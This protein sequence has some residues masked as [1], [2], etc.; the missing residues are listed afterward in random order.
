MLSIKLQNSIGPCVCFSPAIGC[1][2]LGQD[3]TAWSTINCNTNILHIFYFPSMYIWTAVCSNDGTGIFSRESCQHT[4]SNI[5][6]QFDA[7]KYDSRNATHS[8]WKHNVFVCS[9][10][11]WFAFSFFSLFNSILLQ[12][13]RG[14]CTKKVY[15][16]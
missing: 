8:E 9:V 4:P 12:C 6:Y 15:A 16:V 3:N 14:T 1:A 10:P 7:K 2:E 5:W 11:T 13:E